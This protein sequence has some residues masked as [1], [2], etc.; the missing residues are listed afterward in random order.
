MAVSKTF[1]QFYTEKIR[2]VVCYEVSTPVF[3]DRRG[4]EETN[5]T[6]DQQYYQEI[7]GFRLLLSTRTRPD[8]A[9][10]NLLTRHCGRSRKSHV[11]SAKR[12][13]RYLEETRTYAIRICQDESDMEGTPIQIGLVKRPIAGPLRGCL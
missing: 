6:V 10:V 4:N 11:I 7:V 2:A 1:R 13:L 12:V 9:E 5:E 8:I 3:V